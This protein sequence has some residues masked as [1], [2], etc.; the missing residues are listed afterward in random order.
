[1]NWR[2]DSRLTVRIFGRRAYCSLGQQRSLPRAMFERLTLKSIDTRAVL[3]PLRRSVVSK[4]GLFSDWPVVLIDLYTNEGI[5][6]RSYLEPYLKNSVRYIIPIIR[7]LGA[8]LAGKPLAPLDSFHANRRSLNLVGYEGVAMIAVSGVDMAIWDA[9]AKAAGLPL[10]ALLGGTVGPVPA[11]NSNGLWL[12]DVSML[13]KEAEELVAEGGFRGLKL[14]LGRDR[15]A[16]DLAAIREVRTVVGDDFKLMVDF[17]QGLP[18]GDALHRCHALDEQGLYWFEEPITY[19]NLSGYVQLTRELET[20]VQIGENFY[21][22]RDLFKAI[23]SGACDYVMPDLMRIGGV[24]GWLRAAPIAAAAGLQVST[25]LYPE[26][27]AHLMR[28]TETAHW[29]EWQDW[30][31]PV[32]KQPFALKNGFLEVP[33]VPGIGIEWNEGAV[34]RYRY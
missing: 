16:D 24:S 8:A 27:A 15:L 4:V 22:P 12:V 34:D 2:P 26:V 28:V 23:Q 11:Y 13:A 18:L 6:G 10:A 20:P 30:A 17:N 29:L 25:H 9:L 3:V 5:V 32:L 19:D 31:Y 14:R 7:D 1:M 33:N 21:G